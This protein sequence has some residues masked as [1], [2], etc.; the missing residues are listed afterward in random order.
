MTLAEAACAVQLLL[1]KSQ[2]K[3]IL[4]LTWKFLSYV[5]LI[6]GYDI[7]YLTNNSYCSLSTVGFC[8][9]GGFVKEALIVGIF[10][11]G[12]VRLSSEHRDCTPLRRLR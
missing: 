7:L 8:S 5:L 1:Y 2:G 11:G 9:G 6:W 12:Y 3:Q 10:S 4:N